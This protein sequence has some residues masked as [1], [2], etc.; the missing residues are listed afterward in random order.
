LAIDGLAGV[1]AID[2]SAGAGA[3]AG[4][5]AAIIPD[6]VVF[7]ATAPVTFWEDDEPLM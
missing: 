5:N 1:T 7:E 2:T 4:L 3:P 6:H